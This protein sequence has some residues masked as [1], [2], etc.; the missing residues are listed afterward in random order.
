[1]SERSRELLSRLF[2]FAEFKGEQE[3]VV[4]HVAAGG[5]AVVLFPTGSGKSLCYQL[6]ALLRGGVGVVVSPL[7][8]LMDDQVAA[9]GEVGVRAA[10]LHSNL[11]AR[12][13]S[14]VERRLAAGELDLVYVAPERVTTERCLA[15]LAKAPLALFAIDEAHCVSQWGHD[16]RPEYLDLAQLAERFPGVPR[17][18]LTATADP[19]TR[20]EIVDKLKLAG[21]R[22][23]LAS[24]DRPN[25]RYRL[26]DKEEGGRRQL[27]GF[28][29]D[30]HRGHAGIVYRATR[31]KVDAT[32]E[33][34][35][36]R[37][38]DAVAYHAGL[39]P[40]VRRAALDRFRNDEGIVVVATIAFGMGI[41]RPDLRFVA[42]LDL[43]KSLEA[44]HQETGRAGRDGLPA[45]AWLAYS[46]GDVVQIR[47]FIDRGAAPP[48]R[49][50]VE[51]R[52]LDALVAYC[53]TTACRRQVLLR[54]FGEERRVACGNCDTCLEPIATWNATVAAQKAL[55]AAVRTGERFGVEHLIDVLVGEPTE[56]V[57]R[58]RHERLPTFGVGGELDRKGWRRVFHQLV[59]RGY[60]EQDLDGYNTLALTEAARPVLKGEVT[61]HLRTER[62]ALKRKRREREAPSPLLAPDEALYERLRALRAELAKA[63]GVPAYVVFHDVTLVAIAAL[64]PVDLAQ[65]ATVPGVGEKKLER[66][67][68]RVLACVRA[69]A[70]A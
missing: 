58:N 70:P 62:K 18:A 69:A 42:H 5:D 8:A 38:L 23:F 55:S 50:S 63:G 54:Y 40:E 59:A 43:P 25:L 57:Q 21:A 4:D 26:V 10:A 11:P 19:P 29:E 52:K 48:E 36:Q 31:A 53:E 14:A 15:L 2:G 67:G 9:M 45:D 33:L 32:A 22:L 37:G 68:E 64:R 65:L 16:F 35:K 61:V 20:R 3:A 28:L 51:R 13:Q 39:A 41:D 46:V 27:Q 6:P 49:K 44:Y 24:F 47:W 7:I 66:Y 1:V 17:I 34:L 12:D 56:K 30:E 60:L